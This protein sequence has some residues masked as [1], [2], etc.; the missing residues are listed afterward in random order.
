MAARIPTASLGLTG[1]PTED[2]N[3]SSESTNEN[4]LQARF[5]EIRTKYLN[6]PLRA[7]TN[8]AIKS[9]KWSVDRIVVF[10]LGTNLWQLAQILDVAKFLA[11]DGSQIE[12]FAQDLIYERPEN[13]AFVALLKNSNVQVLTVAKGRPGKDTSKPAADYITSKTFVYAP[14]IPNW[15]APHLLA[16]SVPTGWL[17]SPIDSPLFDLNYFPR[18]A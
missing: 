6:H 15:Y 7:E 9:E 8:D 3:A 5:E 2:A 12:I 10:G 14:F 1:S 13:Q 17:G 16:G 4:T 18:T 11:S